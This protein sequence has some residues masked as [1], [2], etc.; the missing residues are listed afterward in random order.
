[1]VD[2]ESALGALVKGYSSKEDL[3]WLTAVF[4]DQALKLKASIYIDRVATDANPGDGPSRAR[5][6]EALEC[7]WKQWSVRFPEVVLKGLGEFMRKILDLP[8]TKVG[9]ALTSEI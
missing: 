5:T 6:R 7:K 8:G 1:M 3:S 9:E 2:S 4:W